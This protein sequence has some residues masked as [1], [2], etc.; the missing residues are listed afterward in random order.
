M[1]GPRNSGIPYT[2]KLGDISSN[3]SSSDGQ[4][5]SDLSSDDDSESQRLQEIVC[6]C[7][8]FGINLNII[9]TAIVLNLSS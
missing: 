4:V 9:A 3:S 7:S 2:K 8:T 1:V 6:L 5:S